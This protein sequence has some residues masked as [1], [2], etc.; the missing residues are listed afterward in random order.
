MATKTEQRDEFVDDDEPEFESNQVEVVNVG[1]STVK[2][3]IDG[4]R[5]VLKPGHVIPIHKSYGL[6]RPT[7]PNRDPLPSVVELLT[8]RKV[9]P[10]TDPRAK[11]FL[12]TKGQ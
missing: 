4:N 1:P 12:S 11:Q 9:L 7:Q 5:I 8:D 3:D 10:V 2:F 6:P